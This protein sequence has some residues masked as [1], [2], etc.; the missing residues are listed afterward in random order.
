MKSIVKFLTYFSALFIVSCIEPHDML[1]V[2]NSDG[3]CYREFTGK[4]DY[5][6]IVGDT[7]SKFNP[8]PVEIDST[9]NISWKFRDSE[10]F[11]GYPAK[12]STVDSIEKTIKLRDKI[13]S[14]V[15]KSDDFFVLAR[16]NYATVQEMGD[17]FRLKRSHD[18]SNLKVNY[19]LETKF[20]WFYTF[21]TYKETYLKVK[22]NFQIPIEKYMSRDEALFWFTGQPD[23]VQ[24]MNG[25]EM[26]E[27][28]GD[29]EDKYN[30]WFANNNWNNEFEILIENYDQ[31]K[32]KPVSKERLKLMSD[33]IFNR[34]DKDLPDFSMEE[35]LNKYFKTTV[36]S[37]L[38]KDK[39]SPMN[40]YEDDFDKQEFVQYFGDA[41]N[42]KLIMPGKIIQSNSALIQG[43]TLN[44]KLTAYR[45]IPSDY[46]IQAQSRKANTW[47]FIL[48]GIIVIIA[49]GSFLW[50]PKERS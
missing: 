18:W 9:W 23:L 4:T 27:Y 31:I 13:N 50:K 1:T 42:Y 34:I 11:S 3:S 32:D 48:T 15:E 22:T 40:K 33:T 30:K 6:F 19:S 2:I 12:S 28:V 24:G 20:R 47:A 25:V 45:M 38:W 44:W 14:G 37:V 43:D 39:L 26:R 35:V 29:L 10:W 49:V 16:R 41:F 5:S 7:A 17:K 46:I 36:F 8:L 21:Y